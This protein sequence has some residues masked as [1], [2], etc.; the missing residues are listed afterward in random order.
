M[1]VLT[2]IPITLTERLEYG[3]EM[4]IPASWQEFLDLLE[5]CEYDIEYDDGEIIS[6][7]GYAVELHETLVGEII[8]FIRGILND[9]SF[10][11]NGS[12]L[13]LH[14]PGFVRRYYNADCAVVKGKSE[15]I[16]LRGDMKSVAN[17][18][19]VVEILSPTNRSFNLNRKFINYKK[20]P[21]LQQILFIESTERKVISHKRGDHW[22]AET[23]S[24]ADD[25]IP[26]LNQGSFSL[27]Q[28]YTRVELIEG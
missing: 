27:D 20:I 10:R 2:K 19:L 16:V 22:E 6:L 7:M 28:L 13:A 4:R 24:G 14:I 1:E 12:N 11:V 17:P 23:F 5:K 8:Y 21:S 15:Y 18:I 26:V 3:P 25:Q 9:V